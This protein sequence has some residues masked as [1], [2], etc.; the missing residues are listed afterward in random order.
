MS[1][2]LC[3]G[4]RRRQDDLE[5][6][7]IRAERLVQVGELSSA[8][9]ALEGA[10]LAPGNEATLR[11][12]TDASRRPPQPREPLP[13]EVL[14]HVPPFAFDVD[15]DVFNRNLRLSKKGTAG[16]PL[17]PDVRGLHCCSRSRENCSRSIAGGSH[18]HHQNGQV[19]GI[20][21]TRWRCQGHCRG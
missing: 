7:A 21:Q 13:P 17:L 3:R 15:E 10:A 16:R 6:R 8:R 2:R 4:R 18:Q 5:L 9:Q 19:D 11:Q 20:V 12:L 1:R 14:N